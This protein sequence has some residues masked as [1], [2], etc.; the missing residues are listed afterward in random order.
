M[1]GA[2]KDEIFARLTEA[3]GQPELA[4]D[5]KYATHLARGANQA[6]LDT[7]INGWTNQHPVEEI[8]QAM[9]T[10][11]VPAGRVYRAPDMLED[12]HFKAREAIIEV[13]TQTQG[14]LKMQNAFPK[15]SRTPSGV[16]RPAP[17]EPGQHNAEVYRELLDLNEN[18]LTRLAKAGIV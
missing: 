3:M 5:P 14:K 9:I 2:N 16:R 4:N 17:A 10:H 18:D 12:P 1:I 7:I 15:L 6:E 13:D 11:S 8:E